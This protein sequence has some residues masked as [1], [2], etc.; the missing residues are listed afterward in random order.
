MPLIS[1]IIK[2]TESMRVFALPRESTG[3]ISMEQLSYWTVRY[4][5]LGHSMRSLENWRK[6]KAPPIIRNFHVELRFALPS[7]FSSLLIVANGRLS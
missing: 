1:D 6:K 4:T 5:V 7:R 2:I 3:A